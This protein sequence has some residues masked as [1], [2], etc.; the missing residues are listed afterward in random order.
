[1][2]LLQVPQL[3]NARVLGFWISEEELFIFISTSTSFPF[4]FL[5]WPLSYLLG[6]NATQV[7][8]LCKPLWKTVM[9]AGVSVFSGKRSRREGWKEKPA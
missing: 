1:M 8:L 4:L 5:S 7:S 2:A 9:F 3:R 6:T